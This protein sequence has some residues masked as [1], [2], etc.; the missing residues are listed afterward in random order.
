MGK[1]GRVDSPQ[2]G[3]SQHNTGVHP[4]T[5]TRQLKFVTTHLT[6][7][8]SASSPVSSPPRA[9][10]STLRPSSCARGHT[11]QRAASRRLQQRNTQPS[12]LCLAPGQARN[13]LN[14]FN[15]APSFQ[16]I[17]SSVHRQQQSRSGGDLKGL[18]LCLCPG[19]E[20]TKGVRTGRDS[21]GMT[22]HFR[23][24]PTRVLL[25]LPIPHWFLFREDQDGGCTYS[26]SCAQL[27]R[28]HHIVVEQGWA[29]YSLVC[30]ALHY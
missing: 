6:A 22:H 7:G 27:C 30:R 26:M 4:P 8:P 1:V 20:M 12:A 10:S 14:P 28:A 23:L 18:A 3:I 2:A 13:A 9:P 25:S 17:S 24:K 11:G 19:V 21:E 15:L 16:T 29:P 5:T